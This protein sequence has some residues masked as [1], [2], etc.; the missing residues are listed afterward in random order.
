MGGSGGVVF[1]RQKPLLIKVITEKPINLT[2]GTVSQYPPS[3]LYSLTL[4]IEVLKTVES[5]VEQ[6][7]I[8]R[9]DIRWP[10]PLPFLFPGQKIQGR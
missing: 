5:G 6:W 3:H 10:N 2:E 8:Q 9:E 4:R 1:K 7:A